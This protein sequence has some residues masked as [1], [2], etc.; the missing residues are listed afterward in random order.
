MKRKKIT[1]GTIKQRQKS[2]SLAL[3]REIEKFQKAQQVKEN[4]KYGR[5]AK[6]ISFV[7]ATKSPKQLAKF[8][9]ESSK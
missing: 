8:I 4:I 1:V 5:K 3:I 7:L 2:I 6:N 9:L